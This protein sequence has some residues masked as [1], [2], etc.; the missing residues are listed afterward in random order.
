MIS[1]SKC[2]SVGCPF[3]KKEHK[4][5]SYIPHLNGRDIPAICR[6]N[7]LPLKVMNK[8]PQNKF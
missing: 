5:I 6:Y 1:K 8:C 3:Y 4:G 7:D 2:I